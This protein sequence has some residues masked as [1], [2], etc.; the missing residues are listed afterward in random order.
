MRI[1]RHPIADAA[2]CEESY[3]RER[4]GLP[5]WVE[6]VARRPDNLVGLA[7]HALDL[8]R[9]GS[10]AA[11]QSPELPRALRVAA[12][13][14][15]GLFLVDSAGGQAVRLVLGETTVTC[16]GPVE[17]SLVHASRWITG[18]WLA[19]ICR[20]SAL[21]DALCRTPPARLRASST[22]HPEYRYL[23]AD[24][25]QGFWRGEQDT[26][27]RIIAAMRATD[28]NRPD[29]SARDWVLN[30][31]V[32]LIQLLFYAVAEDPRFSQALAQGV[33]LHKA[34]WSAT[35]ERRADWEG[36]VSFGLTALAVLGADRG[37][38]VDVESEYLL[39]NLPGAA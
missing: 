30:I 29:V 22:Q 16:A 3:R 32:P 5:G 7:R 18:F 21:L 23:L 6:S 19:I 39:T 38:P 36:F 24:A 35:A 34:Y 15:A 1:P 4:D 11:P 25:L 27:A 17:E 31:D 28:P 9:F 8:V 13:A 33:E 12:Q 10:V 20:D 37:L 14:L 26:P 2:R